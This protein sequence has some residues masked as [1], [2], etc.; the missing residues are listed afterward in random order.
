MLS[1]GQVTPQATGLGTKA[2]SMPATQEQTSDAVF[3]PPLPSGRR[4][5]AQPDS[6]TGQTFSFGTRTTTV[7]LI[8]TTIRTIL[9]V[10]GP[11][12]GVSNTKEIPQSVAKALTW[13]TSQA[14]EFILNS[15]FLHKTL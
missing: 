4:S 1:I 10:A 6:A 11:N 15:T 13:T 12:H 2:S 7:K 3:T 8:S 5:S 14:N 9:S